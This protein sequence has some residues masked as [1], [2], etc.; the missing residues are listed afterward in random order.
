[1]SQKKMFEVKC[2]SCKQATTVPFEPTKGKPVY[3]KTCFAKR[4]TNRPVRSSEPIRFDINNA[5][6]IRRDKH[7]RRKQ[8]PRSVFKK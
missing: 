2:T 3:C 8:K 4:R 6:A 1:M 5:W 7:T